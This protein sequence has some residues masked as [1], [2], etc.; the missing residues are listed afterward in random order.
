MDYI[1]TSPELANQI[2]V[3][4]ETKN[5]HILLEIFAINAEIEGMKAEN[6]SR[7]IEANA[8]NSN[9]SVAYVDSDFFAKAEE[10]R[11]LRIKIS[12]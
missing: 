7:E 5:L 10:L 1:E 12:K 9:I 6:L 2:M 3:K 11:A 8:R 4:M